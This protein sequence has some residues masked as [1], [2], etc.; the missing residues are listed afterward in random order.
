M[1]QLEQMII[2]GFESL[3]GLLEIEFTQ[4]TNYYG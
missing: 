1:I 4:D 3:N 2:E